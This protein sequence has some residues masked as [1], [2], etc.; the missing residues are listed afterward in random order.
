MSYIEWALC[1]WGSPSDDNLRKGGPWTP[2]RAAVGAQAPRNGCMFVSLSQPYRQYGTAPRET[3]ATSPRTRVFLAIEDPAYLQSVRAIFTRH[4]D[5]TLVGTASTLME[6]ARSVE[7]AHPHIVVVS[8]DIT[9]A[10]ELP[11][12]HGI[13]QKCPNTALVALVPEDDDAHVLLAINAGAAAC[14]RKDALPE[15]L[16]GI[17]RNIRAGEYPIQYTLLGRS[18]VAS[19]VLQQVQHMALTAASASS[20]GDCPLSPRETEVL[21][22]IAHGKSNKEIACFLNISEQTVKNHV[23]AILRKLDA[24][25]RTHAVVR[26]LRYGWIALK[27]PDLEPTA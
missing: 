3:P 23:N 2:R 10:R 4:T 8:L 26:A 17:V 18:R 21:G 14:V 12:V 1:A 22:V 9:D 6:G 11:L 20:G 13:K 15:F 16:P 25:D 5:M 7:A 19:H 24:N 27:E